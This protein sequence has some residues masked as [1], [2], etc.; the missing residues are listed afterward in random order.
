MGRSDA[1][2]PGAQAPFAASSP[3]HRQGGSAHALECHAPG[4]P[5]SIPTSGARVAGAR[6]P[7]RHSPCAANCRPCACPA[8]AKTPR[9]E[10]PELTYVSPA[11]LGRACGAQHI[12]TGATELLSSAVSESLA[13][14]RWTRSRCTRRP[15]PL[16]PGATRCHRPWR[17]GPRSRCWAVGARDFHADELTLIV[18]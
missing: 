14:W 18:K 3:S 6:P 7:S 2:G 1:A 13:M 9:L 4:L 12:A 15:G 17:E 16:G 5:G 11:G 8:D 10:G